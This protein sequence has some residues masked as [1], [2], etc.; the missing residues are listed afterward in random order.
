MPGLNLSVENMAADVAALVR[1]LKHLETRAG[2]ASSDDE[3]AR[4]EDRVGQVREQL[5]LRGAQGEAPQRRAAK[6]DDRP[7]EAR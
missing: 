4:L 5:R 2:A 1:E 7:Q 3:K 6:R